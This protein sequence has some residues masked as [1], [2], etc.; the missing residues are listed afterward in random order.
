MLESRSTRCPTVQVPTASSDQSSVRLRPP[1]VVSHGRQALAASPT[2]MKLQKLLRLELE[3]T[4][5]PSVESRGYLN[6]IRYQFSFPTLLPVNGPSVDDPAGQI[7]RR[8]EL[9]AK[10]WAVFQA[11]PVEDGIDHPGE[12]VIREA[13]QSM[14]GYPVLEWLKIFSVDMVHP[15]FAASVLRCLGRQQRPGTSPW[16]IEVIRKALST[17]AVDLRDAA[18]QAAESWG[19][20]EM[21]DVLQEH[22]DPVPWLQEYI[23]DILN[24]IQS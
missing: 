19:G 24:D 23:L 6:L 3:Q 15:H 11:N 2:G 7:Q 10:L 1:L 12:V 22:T 9:A 18:A 16:R 5:S 20:L 21:R 13:L 4:F 8:E 17:D 14:D